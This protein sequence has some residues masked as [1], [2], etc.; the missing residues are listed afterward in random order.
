MKAHFLK[1][2]DYDKYANILILES[3]LVMKAPEKPVQ[4]MAH[5]LASQQIW[6]N[7]CKELPAVG[8]A[9][10]PDWKAETF[11]GIIRENYLNWT[12][13]IHQLKPDDFNK[14]VAYQNSKGESFENQLSDVIAHLIN[15][16]THNRAQAGQYLKLAGLKQLPVT[17]YIFYMRNKDT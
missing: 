7:R 9:L 14:F 3:I 12:D 15:H 11:E 8:S 17:D 16:G 2:F 13:F 4:L 10:W 5:L 6:L 1:M